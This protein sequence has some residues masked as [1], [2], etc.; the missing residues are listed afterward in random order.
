MPRV[1]KLLAVIADADDDRLPPVA[2]TC[3][4]SLVR[5]FLSLHGEIY[6]AGKHIHIWHRSNEVSRR[7]ETIPGIGPLLSGLNLSD[8]RKLHKNIN[9]AGSLISETRTAYT[10]SP[11][12]AVRPLPAGER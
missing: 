2:R 1:K 12:P 8:R 3:L 6:A 4:E 5:Q 7:L 11:G 10:P 9:L